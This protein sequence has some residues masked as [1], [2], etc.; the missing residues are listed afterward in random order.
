[1]IPMPG[2]PTRSM[3]PVTRRVRGLALAAAL[4]ASASAATAVEVQGHRGARGLAPENTLAGFAKAIELGVAT[5]ETDVAITRDDVAVISHDPDLNPAIVRGPNGLWLDARGPAI[6]S[7]TLDELKRYDIGRLKPDSSYGRQW[8]LQWPVDGQRFPTLAE[9][10][11]RTTA[12]NP[13]IRYSIETK[14]EPSGKVATA[15]PETF[16]RLTLEELKRANATARTSLLSFDWRTLVLAKK[17]AP[18]IPTTCLTAEFSRFDTT[19]VDASGASPWHAGL[20]PAE[21]GN[22]LPRLIKAAGCSIWSANFQSMTR[23]RLDEAHALGLK[24]LVWTV[25]EPADIE[26]MI[27]LGVDGIVTDYPDRG[28]ELVNR[29]R[30]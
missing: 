4:C 20:K 17:L 12:A 16:V 7:L 13:A 30:K 26:R 19:K 8:S 22:S 6:R 1:M 9:F 11:A 29:G 28:L 27:A 18:E 23:E 14:V 10:L 3:S 25:N 5:L 21:H 15:D 24:V 2:V